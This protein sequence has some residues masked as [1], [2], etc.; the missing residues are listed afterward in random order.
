MN[1]TNYSTEGEFIYCVGVLV[2]VLLE[3]I[4]CSEMYMILDMIDCVS[5]EVPRFCQVTIY[6]VKDSVS[7]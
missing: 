5:M 6:V 3:L 7:M 1:A 4:I 2:R